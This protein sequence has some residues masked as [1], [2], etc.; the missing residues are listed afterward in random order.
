MSVS[1]LNF[2]SELARLEIIGGVV[3][4]LLQ[5]APTQTYTNW[6]TEDV[7]ICKS[8][9]AVKELISVVNNYLVDLDGV[10]I[11]DTLPFPPLSDSHCR[12]SKDPWISY[13]DSG[14]SPQLGR[15]GALYSDQAKL[16]GCA[17]E[18]HQRSTTSLQN[19]SFSDILSLARELNGSM[20]PR[21]GP[22]VCSRTA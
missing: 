10:S 5:P 22:C 11:F 1:E 9:R 6:Y 8:L 2:R 15:L 14:H 17:C 12:L 7:D 13:A 18:C 20:R 4:L 16:A 19:L 21:Q 3:V